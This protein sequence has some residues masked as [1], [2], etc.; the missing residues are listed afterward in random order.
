ML[1]DNVTFANG[2]TLG[3]HCE[4]GDNVIIGGLTAVHQFVRIGNNAFIGGCSAVAGDVIPFTIAVGNRA[5]LRGLNIVGLKRSGLPRSEIHMLRRCY[6]VLFDP[7]RPVLENIEAAKAEFGG[8][9]TAL[10]IIDFI[11]NRGKRI[12]TVPPLRNGGGDDSD[13]ED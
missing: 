5:K 11:D 6:R 13:D 4:I 1:G 2:A 10:R 12:Y 9:P 8:S 3:G 7:A